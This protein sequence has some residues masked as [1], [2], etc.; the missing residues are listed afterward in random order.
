MR[1]LA[2]LL[3]LALGSSAL[4]LPDVH[5]TRLVADPALSAELIGFAYANDL[6]L[7]K[8]DGSGVRRLTSHPGVES[9]PRFSPDGRRVAFTGQ[10]DG[11]TDVFVVPV[12]GGAPRR[13]TWHPGNDTAVGFTPDGQAVLFVSGRGSH[14]TRFQQLYSVP[15]GGGWPTRLPLPSVE[16][17]ALSPDGRTL[18]YLPLAEPFSQWKNYRGGRHARLLLYDMAS[19]ATR[20]VPQPAG[21]CNDT[22]PQWLDGQLYFRSDRDGEFGLYSYDPATQAVARLTRHGDFPVQGLSAAA[23]RVLYEQAGWL[24]LFDVG[25]GSAQRLRLGVPADPVET[26]ARWASGAKWVRDASLSP[27]GA[28]VAF[29]LRGEIV[30][31][32]REKGDDRNLTR[33]PGA[34]D[35]SPAW[36]PDGKSIAWFSDQ[37]GEYALLVGPQDGSAAPRRLELKGS[38][39]YEDLQWSPD[40]RQLSLL[41]NSRTLWIVDVATGAHTRVDQE[42]LYGPE[43]ITRHAH[44][45]WSPDSQWLA[46]T[47]PTLTYI[48]QV[49]LYSLRQ[50]QSF[51]VSDGLADARSPAFDRNGR[52]LYFTV[53]TD[54]GPVQDWFAQSGADAAAR[55][56]LYLAVL[57]RGVES[58]VA[59]PSD[60]EQGPA[61]DEPAE[62]KG[63]EGAAAPARTVVVKVDVDGLSER[64]VALPLKPAGYADLQAGPA[65]Q[66]LYLKQPGAER[67]DGEWSLA[68]YDFEKRKEE[69][70]L[71][72]LASYEVS[73]DGQ[74]VL[75][76]VKDDWSICDLGDKL[77]TAKF[78]L[79]VEGVQVRVDPPAEWR[80]MFHEAWRINRDF[81]YDPGF[82]GADWPAM[83]ARYEPFLDHLSTRNDLTRVIRWLLS[84]LS[85]GHSYQS[86]GEQLF[87]PPKVPGGL[88]G[89]DYAV[90]DGRYRFA[91]VYGG[92]NWVADLR[93]PLGEPGVDVRAG[94]YLLAVEGRELRPPEEPFSRFERT[95]GRRVQITVGPSPDGQGSRTVTVVPV[96]SEATLRNR[97]WIEGNLR[98]VTERSGGR[99][100]YVYVPNTAGAGFDSFKRYFYPQAD[101]QAVIVDERYNG[102]GQVAD[103]YVD[104]LRRPPIS[105]WTMRYGA[106]LKTPLAGIH[107]PKVM[108]ID[109]TA[110]SGGDLLPWMFRRLQL[111]PLVG[112]RT[113]GGLV[114]ILGF[115]VLMDGG[116]VTA[117][118]LAFWDEQGY[119]VE[120]E[121]V[122]PDVEVEQDPRAVAAGHDPQLEKALELVLAELERNPPA[123]TPRP[124]FPVRVRKPE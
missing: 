61:K 101:R 117:P 96:E 48:Q 100:A 57:A 33:S 6:W 43:R 121:G 19:Q 98:W 28:R 20:V 25:S 88:L 118:N 36:S 38:G 56:S 104:L 89:A 64:V 91:R 13:L 67:P 52:Y 50:K 47:R 32:P 87:E 44:R 83:R 84:E 114:G 82:H 35:R 12:E 110:G 9:G 63:K 10:Y 58:P 62:G 22:D 76:R 99:V 37:G 97:D 39:F 78:K 93:A 5:D 92:L 2:L 107:G 103:Y 15:V 123:Q 51:P 45:A 11:N 94:E 1:S 105:H 46:Y 72:G 102:G 111:G 74:R 49:W 29:E 112:K 34:H 16:K 41:D 115:P 119:S 77:D 59:R 71:E 27:S 85:V 30:T 18:A 113:W 60:E 109:E 26:R 31:L 73:H 68:R 65:G 69:T 75:V 24:H 80:Q 55:R 42:P 108:L 106:T 95:A 8:L 66:L 86:G 40:G 124:P 7:A 116:Q 79:N 14:T 21:R 53:S 70:L 3:G 23:G 17:A 81:F 54:A 4:A 90:E 120:N 122:P